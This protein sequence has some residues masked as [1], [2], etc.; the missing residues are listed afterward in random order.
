MAGLDEKT[1]MT[2]AK[3]LRKNSLMFAHVAETDCVPLAKMFK[4]EHFGMGDDLIK[5]D[6]KQERMFMIRS[7]IIERIH[8]S[9]TKDPEKYVEQ[10]G[11]P[12]SNRSIGSLHFLRCDPAFSTVKCRSEKCVAY[13]LRSD[14]FRAALQASPGLSEGV[15]Y[16]LQREVRSM[17]K[18]LR[19]TPLVQQ[20]TAPGGNPIVA[21][22][23]AAG[24]EAFYRSALNAYIN[25]HITGEKV[26]RLFPDMH[27]QVPVRIMYINGTKGIRAYLDDKID[28][29][30]YP[31]PALVGFAM[32]CA[33]GVGMTPISSVLEAANA[34]HKNKKPLYTRWVDGVSAR[35]VREIL[36]A[37]GLNQATDYIE[38]RVPS[39]VKSGQLRNLLASL[40]AGVLSGY[41]SHVPHNLSALKL[42]SPKKGYWELFKDYAHQ[43]ESRMPKEWSQA[44]KTLGARVVAV[45]MPKAVATRTVQIVGTFILL[46]GGI[47]MLRDY[48]PF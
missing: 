16:S 30:D 40:T 48:S 43:N 26:A 41:L 20:K 46:N 3:L 36:F 27:V 9:S 38:E 4:E 19:R 6:E 22:S 23:I 5:Q 28:P 18:L 44:N 21:T 10:F 45:L 7:G 13:T 24:F 25:A 11:N 42:M 2:V 32:M 31:N 14:E 33:P 34:G 39:D 15:I 12:A 47:Y 17:S 29:Y 35:C 8:R 1:A 37:A